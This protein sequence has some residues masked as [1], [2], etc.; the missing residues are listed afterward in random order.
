MK[1][2]PEDKLAVLI[3]VLCTLLVIGLCSSAR[4]AEFTVDDRS[5]LHF[6]VSAGIG[7]VA[8]SAMI[9]AQGDHQLSNRKYVAFGFCMTPGL[10]K[11]F[12]ID[13]EADYG[14]LAF[15]TLGCLVG[16][17]LSE[18]MWLSSDGRVISVMGRF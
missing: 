12:V 18:T 14:D 15:N 16:V 9:A 4:A 7:Y 13:S 17:S 5:A 8:N 3:L 6:G 10:A 2:N 1:F 11:E